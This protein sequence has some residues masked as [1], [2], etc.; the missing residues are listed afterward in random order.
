[1]R[2][3]Y[4]GGGPGVIASGLVWLAS[5]IVAWKGEAMTSMLVFF[6]GGM[7]IHPI[8]IM[9]SKLIGRSGKHE[10]G[11]PLSTLALESTILIFIG[12]FIAYT[13][14]HSVGDWF[15]VIMAMIIGSRYLLFQS[16][17]GMK[18]YW[19]LGALFILIGFK[20]IFLAEPFHYP[21]ISGG[22]MELLIAIVIFVKTK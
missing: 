20:G 15:Y 4:Y 9:L 19:L 16:M 21:A 22:V 11:N 14:F 5:G 6:V 3:S 1:M 7:L 12:L 10:K 8:G 18:I 13:V 2:E 17:Y